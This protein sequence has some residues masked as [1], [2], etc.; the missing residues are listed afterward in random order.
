M[1]GFFFTF[2]LKLDTTQSVLLQGKKVINSVQVWYN[3]FSFYIY[4]MAT[5]N[6]I[7]FKLLRLYKT[8]PNG[9]PLI[10]GWVSPDQTL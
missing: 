7:P 8:N 5:I 1:L 3:I 6:N 10:P 2:F 4:P 9:I